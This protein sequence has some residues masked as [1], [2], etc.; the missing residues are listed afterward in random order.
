MWQAP[1]DIRNIDI[2][3]ILLASRMSVCISILTLKVF[4]TTLRK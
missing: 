4:M 3:S 1:N 2:N